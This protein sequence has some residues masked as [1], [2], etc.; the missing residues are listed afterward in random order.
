MIATIQKPKNE[1][2]EISKKEI[3][4][5]SIPRVGHQ[6]LVLTNRDVSALTDLQNENRSCDKQ[7]RKCGANNR[8]Q[9]IS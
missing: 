2:R 9:D 1:K 8:N 7:K 5:I 3:D 4:F 6:M